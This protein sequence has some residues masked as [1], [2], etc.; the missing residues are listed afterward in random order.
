MTIALSKTLGLATTDTNIQISGVHG[1]ATQTN[2][3]VN[4]SVY[5]TVKPNWKINT[6]CCVLDKITQNIPQVNI[7]K[8]MIP[9]P[10]FCRLADPDFNIPGQI[11]I[12]LGAEVYYSIVYG[13][14]E[15]VFF[16]KI[17]ILMS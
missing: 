6:S 2:K 15:R 17:L 3:T 1:I 5:S 7:R 11:D 9:I 13:A 8:N 12:L 4:L 16:F 14:I 10:E